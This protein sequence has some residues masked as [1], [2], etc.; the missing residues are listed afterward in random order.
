ML[1]RYAASV[2]TAQRHTVLQRLRALPMQALA[3]DGGRYP[4]PYDW[5]RALRA[6]A[7][8]ERAPADTNPHAVRLL[9]VHGAKGLEASLVLLL[10]TDAERS[11]SKS[12]EI[13]IDWPGH[14]TH[15]QQIVFLE[16][17]AVPPPSAQALLE[18]ES[19]AARREEHNAWYVAMTRAAQVLALSAVAPH[20]SDPESWWQ[21]MQQTGLAQA[22][23]LQA[24]NAPTLTP[25]MRAMAAAHRQQAQTAPQSEIATE[26]ETETGVHKAAPATHT[27]AT[28]TAAIHAA[29]HAGTRAA[30]AAQPKAPAPATPASHAS[31][32][33][34]QL[35]AAIA[36]GQ[37]APSPAFTPPAD[38]G[39]LLQATLGEAMHKVL[40]WHR[41]GQEASLSPARQ[42]ALEQALAM[43]F[44][45]NAAQTALV[46]QRTRAITQGE[47]AW[48]WSSSHIEWQANEV[49]IAWQGQCLRIDR[50]VRR[51]AHAGTPA[52]WWVLDFK[53]A[54]AP[55]RQEALK[56]QLATYRQ[57]V[58]ALYPQE[59]V[60]AAFLTA[61]GRLVVLK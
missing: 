58:Q 39:Q 23:P 7:S 8:G 55:Q 46:L 18:Q 52:S 21:Q 16:S 14:H 49:D 35:P 42:H 29:T 61:E 2:P 60:F 33:L 53:S 13:L 44:G 26:T 15:P 51:A 48:I 37:P 22:T 36:G 28:Y 9:T 1:A 41:P 31:I 50:L 11:R 10:N 24:D 25:A 56:T 40:E 34:P 17:G 12:M 6:A 20:R 57:A 3:L 45:L 54:F 43:Q 47:G 32:V 5:V 38:A 30:T 19:A 4:N 59:P 27:A